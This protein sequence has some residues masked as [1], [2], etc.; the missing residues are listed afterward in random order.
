MVTLSS[1]EKI[2]FALVIHNHQ[3]FGNKN[4]IIE[5]IFQTSYFPFLKILETYPRIQVNLHYT[6]FLLDWMG[7]HHPEVLDLLRKLVDREQ[8]ELGGGAY[9]EPVVAVIP[10]VDIRGQTTLLRDRISS[11]FH[12]E[13]QGF[14]TAERAWE[15]H[16]PEILS[17][18]D[19]S[20]SFIDDVS[21]ESVGLSES[22]CFEPY[23]VE[24]RGKYVTIF[25]ILKKA[26]LPDPVQKRLLDD[27]VSEKRSGKR[28]CSLRG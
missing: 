21:F 25:P 14:W 13:P 10:D 5:R 8:V 27:L 15:P 18:M 26:A 7:Q 19:A 3:P 16:L 22:D 9:F 1:D 28:N 17:D 12:R 6:G 2:R 24:S 4:E 23:L 11:L 20:H